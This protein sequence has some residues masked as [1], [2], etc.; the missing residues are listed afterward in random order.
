MTPYSDFNQSPRNMY[1]CQMGKQTMG[2]PA[3]V[4]PPPP[5][6][7]PTPLLVITGSCPSCQVH[8]IT[9]VL[10]G[11]FDRFDAAS[12]GSAADLHCRSCPMCRADF[13]SLRLKSCCRNLLRGGG[14]TNLLL[15]PGTAPQLKYRPPSSLSPQT[16]SRNLR[17]GAY[18]QKL[19]C[20]G[21]IGGNIW[22]VVHT[23]SSTTDRRQAV[24]NSDPSNPHMPHASLRPL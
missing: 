23:G 9:Q 22:D 3:Q 15:L 24:Q 16:N 20:F 14:V 17:H 1:Q 21:S 8:K 11:F 6:H 4:P 12:R 18:C 2:T 10:L 5:P 19:Q 13:Y 7:T